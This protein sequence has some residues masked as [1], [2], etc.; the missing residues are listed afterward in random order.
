MLR[1][2]KEGSNDASALADL[3]GRKRFVQVLAALLLDEY[4]FYLL[5]IV[6]LTDSEAI[7]LV[8]DDQKPRLF[9]T[10]VLPG[11]PIQ[12]LLQLPQ[13]KLPIGVAGASTEHE[14]IHVTTCQANELAIAVVSPPS[15]RF[16]LADL[17]VEPFH[18]L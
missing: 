13:A 7:V 14:V 16:T 1:E 4:G 5:N 9:E 11:A 2:P 18:H 3:E 17:P 8:L 10:A 6:I 12:S 15:A